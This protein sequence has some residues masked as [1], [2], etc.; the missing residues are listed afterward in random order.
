MKNKRKVIAGKKLPYSDVTR[1]D[2][3]IAKN[4]AVDMLRVPKMFLKVILL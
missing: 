1:I 3:Y 4:F 2:D